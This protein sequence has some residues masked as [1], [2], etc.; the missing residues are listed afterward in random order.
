MK[1]TYRLLSIYLDN[2]PLIRT[3]TQIENTGNDCTV[4]DLAEEYSL[5]DYPRC[6]RKVS[7]KFLLSTN[8][9]SEVKRDIAKLPIC[10]QLFVILDQDPVSPIV[11]RLFAKRV[12]QAA[13]LIKDRFPGVKLTIVANPENIDFYKSIVDKLYIL[14][15]GNACLK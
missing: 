6:R 12:L 11:G 9:F 10:H 14:D 5:F 4:P 13:E 1:S 3:D 15:K 7:G 2:K 8:D